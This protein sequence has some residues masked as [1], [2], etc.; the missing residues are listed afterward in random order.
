VPLTGF[1][2]IQWQ[3]DL[4]DPN[5]CHLG[6][7]R[8]GKIKDHPMAWQWPPWTPRHVTFVTQMTVIW[9]TSGRPGWAQGA[10][11]WVRRDPRTNGNVTFVTQMTVIWVTIDRGKSK[12]TQWPAW[13]PCDLCDPNDC[14]LGHIGSTRMGTGCH[15]LP[16]SGSNVTFVTQM[17]VIWV[18]IDREKSKITH[19][20]VLD[21]M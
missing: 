21:P 2:G 12:I 3:C 15:W 20:L 6:H 1:V 4:C 19:W 11:G 13:T 8:S 5:D 14:H 9:V 18:T 16:P 17:T 7:N 10:T